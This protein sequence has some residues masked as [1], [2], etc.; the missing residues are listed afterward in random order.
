MFR[1]RCCIIGGIKFEVKNTCSVLWFKAG[2]NWSLDCRNFGSYVRFLYFPYKSAMIMLY[3]INCQNPLVI[4]WISEYYRISIPNFTVKSP[5]ISKMIYDICSKE[6]KL[7]AD[8]GDPDAQYFLG[9]NLLYG[10][11]SKKMKVQD[12]DI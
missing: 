3:F 2:K 1:E 9:F 12:L 11:N 10:L 8:L 6:L 7:M 5:E 4:A